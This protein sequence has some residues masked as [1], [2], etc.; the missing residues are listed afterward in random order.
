MRSIIVIVVTFFF[1]IMTL[2]SIVT[3]DSYVLQK[4]EIE[5][6][7]DF[8]LEQTMQDSITDPNEI[9]IRT[10]ENFKSQINSKNGTLSVYVLYADEN[11]IDLAIS[12][13]YMQYNGTKK[14]IETRETIIR[15]WEEGKENESV[16]R[17][18]SRDYLYK[19]SD[20]GGLKENSVW[21][22]SELLKIILEKEKVEGVW[23]DPYITFTTKIEK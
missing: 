3:I 22:S 9:A 17:M 11:I 8:A 21:K 14:E 6:A 23:E 20:K 2:I 18:I 15:D 12:F 16:V 19:S 1:C 7:V 5:R 10:V 13:S 4:D